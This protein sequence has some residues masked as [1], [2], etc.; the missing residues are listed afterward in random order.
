MDF[1]DINFFSDKYRICIE[2]E[3]DKTFCWYR[4]D[5]NYWC[6]QSVGKNDNIVITHYK[7]E[8]AFEKI[9]TEAWKNQNYYSTHNDE[10]ILVKVKS[11]VTFPSLGQ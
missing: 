7:E 6:C 9:L 2:T 10:A 5:I 8:S 4:K 3:L 11:K 1:K